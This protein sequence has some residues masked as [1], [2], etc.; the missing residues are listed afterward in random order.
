MFVYALLS[1]FKQN[2][3]PAT[4]KRRVSFERQSLRALS[5]YTSASHREKQHTWVE[6][7]Y[8]FTVEIFERIMDFLEPKERIK[9][10]LLCQV[11]SGIAA[12]AL[13]QSPPTFR[14]PELTALLTSSS[15]IHPYALLVREFIF[16]GPAAD[17]LL[18]GD[19][20][21]SLAVCTNLASLRLEACYQISNLLASFLMEH[22]PFLSRIELPNCSISDSFLIQLIRGVRSLRHIDVSYT[23]VTLAALPLLVRECALLE[24]LDLTG[25]K[26]A[27][28]SFVTE[29]E[30][31]EYYLVGDTL[32]HIKNVRLT[33]VSLSYTQVTD[34][35]VGYVTRHAEC[36][37]VLLLEGCRNLTDKGLASIAM[38]GRQLKELNVGFCC[39]LTDIGLTQLAVHL[40]LPQISP[41]S[42]RKSVGGTSYQSFSE[43][44]P[45]L[46]KPNQ[47]DSLRKINLTACVYLTPTS[48]CLLAEKLTDLETII[49]DGCDK[50][51]DWYTGTDYH[52]DEE[53]CDKDGYDDNESFV[54]AQSHESFQ[55]PSWDTSKTLIISRNDLLRRKSQ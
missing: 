12:E 10:V 2:F 36:I 43:Y 33:Q 31:S 15:T 3:S 14:F 46:E 52:I 16:Q 38:H 1:L 21:A 18:M 41:S 11:W 25:C 8:V 5:I 30:E 4:E 26:P 48:V 7:N 9:L 19:L 29:Y 49:L 55:Y 54:S 27:P 37:E 20:K 13:Y 32:K 34:A 39:S 22:A 17:D 35:L 45:Q 42:P 50:V 40:S 28:E 44:Q 24:T 23:N 53:M 51:I 47:T 6:P